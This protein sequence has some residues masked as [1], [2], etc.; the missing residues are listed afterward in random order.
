MFCLRRFWKKIGIYDVRKTALAV[1]PKI[2]KCHHL[3]TKW[4]IQHDL[5][6]TSI[7]LE[8][9]I[10]TSLTWWLSHVDTILRS[11]IA[12]VYRKKNM[13]PTFCSIPN[14]AFLPMDC[15]S[16]LQLW[17]QPPADNDSILLQA[18]DWTWRGGR[19]AFAWSFSTA[20]KMLKWHQVVRVVPRRFF[21]TH[22][23]H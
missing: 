23:I 19:P 10:P 5:F 8:N 18:L 14:W 20:W 9:L 12:K 13:V 2:Q 21:K 15:N 16:G 7:Q 4:P 22:V 6:Q 1:A 11:Q 17:L 3:Q